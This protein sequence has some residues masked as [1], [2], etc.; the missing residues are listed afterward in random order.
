MPSALTWVAGL[1]LVKSSSGVLLVTVTGS[2]PFR[3]VAVKVYCGQGKGAQR[4]GVRMMLTIHAAC[5]KT[6]QGPASLQGRHL[7]RVMVTPPGGAAV[8][9]PVV[10][11]VSTALVRVMAPASGMAS[12]RVLEA[13]IVLPPTTAT[14]DTR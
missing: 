9:C 10:L 7:T 1:S 3:G 2:P 12:G 5:N 8:A 14:A 13:G 4:R 6:Q 11:P